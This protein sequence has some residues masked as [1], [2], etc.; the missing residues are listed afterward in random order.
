VSRGDKAID[1]KEKMAIL[2]FQGGQRKR[3]EGKKKGG[4]E[5]DNEDRGG[6]IHVQEV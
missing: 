2:M 3:A 5:D 6:V 4:R 1:K